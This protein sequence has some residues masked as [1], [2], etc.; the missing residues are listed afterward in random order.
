MSYLGIVLVGF[1]L[2]GAIVTIVAIV[3]AG[4]GELIWFLAAR[5]GVSGSGSD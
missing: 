2:S 4:T 5:A 1:K 3:I